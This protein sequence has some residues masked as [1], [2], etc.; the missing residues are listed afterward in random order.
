MHSQFP[1]QGHNG[2]VLR[3]RRDV[4]EA[5]QISPIIYAGCGVQIVL[6]GPSIVLKYGSGTAVRISEGRNMEFVQAAK[7]SKGWTR[8]RLP[9]I[10]DYWEEDNTHGSGHPK[11]TVCIL[12]EYIEGSTLA[13]IW[14]QLDEDEKLHVYGQVEEALNELHSAEA[15]FPGPFR[16]KDC[17]PEVSRGPLFTDYDAGP[18][19]TIRDL[20]EWYNGR[21]QV[22]K[23]FRRIS[24][25]ALNFHFDRL[26]YCHMD[27]AARNLIYSPQKEIWFIDWAFAGAYPPHFETATF[28]RRGD[29]IITAGLLKFLRTTEEEQRK[30]RRLI[31]IGFGLTTG[32][33]AMRSDRHPG[34]MTD[35]I[36]VN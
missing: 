26:V 10:F 24:P 34:L 13:S 23:H 3:S 1:L 35:D 6:V 12:M 11:S 7:Q 14:P 20:E 31:E 30:I 16:D 22:C 27:V 29:G 8:L 28:Q 4:L 2:C 25:A 9:R 15:K 5:A 21:L 19:E 32:A 36:E 33:F 17:P 18:F